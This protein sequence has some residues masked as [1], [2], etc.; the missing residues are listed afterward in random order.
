MPLTL[1]RAQFLKQE[2][3][4]F[5]FDAEGEVAVALEKYSAERLPQLAASPY[6][7]NQKT[8]L[9]VDSFT[10]EGRV[11]SRTVI[12]YFLESRSDLP[13]ADRIAVLRWAQGFIGL[14]TILERSSE[15]LVMM[16]WLTEM[17]YSI[18]LPTE[19][20]DRNIARLK[21]GE[22]VLTRI[23]PLENDWMFSGP[24][25]FLGKLGKPKL[26][27]AIGNFK[28]FH[29]NYLYADAPELLE[30]AWQSVESYHQE[31][32]DYFGSPT[33]TFSGHRLEQKLADFQSY[34]TQRQ[35]SMSGLDGEK[36]LGE[37][38][39]EAGMSRAEMAGTASAMGIDEKITSHVI[40]NQKVSK[41]MTP[42]IELPSHLKNEEYVSILTHPRWGQIMV[43]TYQRLTAALEDDQSLAPETESFV[44]Q[45]LKNMEFK[46]FVWH[47]LA[48]K[49]PQRLERLLQNILDRPHL[50]LSR[51]LDPVLAGFGHPAQPLLPD[52]ASV[53]VHLHNLFQDALSDVSRSKSS[54]SKDRDKPKKK[55]GFG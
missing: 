27:V 16:N 41:M 39:D 38:A 28:K 1:E 3:L 19:G 7:G 24:A 33:I 18:L 48:Q 5:T 46:P 20:M 32:V 15:R 2:L 4:N 44:H 45:C 36:S 23:L 34:M 42:T 14:F 55:M 17:K 29:S 6:Q 22:I 43:S 21:A 13:A 26:A 25:V 30:E 9:V 52:T 49:Y 10:T 51:D 8:E 12:D 37:L 47:Q 50:S 54:K 31:F 35:L 40:E 11:G 53:P